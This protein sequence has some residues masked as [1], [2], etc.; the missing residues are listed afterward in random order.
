MTEPVKFV[1]SKVN[2]LGVGKLQSVDRETQVAAIEYFVSPAGPEYRAIT[3]RQE[4]V[5][6]VTL[7]KQTRVY[8][9][10]PDTGTWRSGRIKDGTPFDATEELQHI[11]G[12]NAVGKSYWVSFPNEVEEAI[13][14]ADLEVRWSRPLEDPIAL[15]Q[16]RTHDSPFW[17]PGRAGLLKSITRQRKIYA[18][19]TG[20]ASASIDLL[21]HQISAVR[22]ILHDPIQRYIL[23]DEV[24]LGKTIEAG[25]IIRQHLLDNPSSAGITIVVPTHLEEQWQGELSDRFHLSRFMSGL[26]PQSHLVLLVSYDDLVARSGRL[27]DPT[28]VVVDEA[29]QASARAYSGDAAD[30][31]FF[32]KLKSLTEKAN[33]VLLLSATPV[34]HHEFEF[35]AMLHLLDPLAYKLEDP[36]AFKRKVRG[37]QDIANILRNLGDN[38]IAFFLEE[39]V[40]EIRNLLQDDSRAQELIKELEPLINDDEDSGDRQ[41]AIRRVRAHVQDTYR[42]DRRLIRARRDAPDIRDWRDPLKRDQSGC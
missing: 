28:L 25:I 42:L 35:L 26:G 32:E 1:R 16:T 7:A 38:S 21:S 30:S 2:S 12:I 15:L 27:D 23:A 19:L 4:S 14:I 20:L 29:H 39:T 3:V 8:A 13:R 40:E 5:E 24:G 6:S 36:E 11:P 37:R 9:P 34:L 41:S 10:N 17:H 31:A 18:G 33:Q 22:R